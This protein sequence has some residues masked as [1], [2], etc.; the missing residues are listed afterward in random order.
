MDVEREDHYNK[1][2]LECRASIEVSAINFLYF[3]YV[4]LFKGKCWLFFYSLPAILL[5]GIL[6][7]VLGLSLIVTV[8]ILLLLCVFRR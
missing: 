5:G 2:L 6:G 1:N 4:L 3:H 7:V 8:V